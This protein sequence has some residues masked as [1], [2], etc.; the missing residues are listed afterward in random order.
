MDAKQTLIGNQ[1]HAAK[2]Y[3]KL[4]EIELG[5]KD[6]TEL[7]YQRC[8]I[9]VGAM[10]ARMEND[11]RTVTKIELSDLGMTLYNAWH[12]IKNNPLL[13]TENWLSYDSWEIRFETLFQSYSYIAGDFHWNFLLT[14]TQREELQHNTPRNI[15]GFN[16]DDFNFEN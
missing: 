7:L 1:V 5:N 12:H 3:E 8:V 4:T 2:F 6:A 15:Y 11:D 13:F 16:M 9:E 10:F 14:D